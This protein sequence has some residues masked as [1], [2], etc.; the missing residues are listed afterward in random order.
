M[1]LR[2]SLAIVPVLCLGACIAS[3]PGSSSTG[4]AAVG[5]GATGLTIVDGNPTHLTALY[6]EAG[7]SL[8]FEARAGE[9]TRD[10]SV[11]DDR[12]RRTLRFR[13]D[14]ARYEVALADEAF[15]VRGD[16][17]G[18]APDEVVG[19]TEVPRAFDVDLLRR[20]FDA[21]ESGGVD[22]GTAWKRTFPSA[23]VEALSSGFFCGTA[24]M[25]VFVVEI[26]QDRYCGEQGCPAT[27]TTYPCGACI[28]FPT[29][30]FPPVAPPYFPGYCH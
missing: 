25:C 7:T 19:D 15:V 16:L 2:Y 5:E 11:W 6:R 23:D 20:G 26:C 29:G 12:G 17:G 18:D 28:G 30:F 21:L 10:L 13:T 24:T 3:P 4:G 22:L 27:N 1:N 8:R 9:D 14:G